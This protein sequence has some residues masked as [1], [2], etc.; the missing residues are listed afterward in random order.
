MLPAMKYKTQGRLELNLCELKLLLF[1]SQMEY[2]LKF[3][4]IWMHH[5]SFKKLKNG[6]YEVLI[7]YSNCSPGP[8]FCKI[9]QLIMQPMS[10]ETKENWDWC[11][12]VQFW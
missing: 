8:N 6:T 3:G 10:K 11:K 5:L 9:L 4:P 2:F 1:S 7:C 12:V